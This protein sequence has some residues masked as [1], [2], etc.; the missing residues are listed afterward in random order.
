MSKAKDSPG[1]TTKSM[2]GSMQAMRWLD[3]KT[4][5]VIGTAHWAWTARVVR[6]SRR[7]KAFGLPVRPLPAAWRLPVKTDSPFYIGDV[8]VSAGGSKLTLGQNGITVLI[9]EK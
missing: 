5:F 4:D 3:Q 2:Y 7:T 9:F 1:I 8:R 6:V